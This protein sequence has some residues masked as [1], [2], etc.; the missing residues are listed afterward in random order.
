MAD[1]IILESDA[2]L[3]VDPQW[4][5]VRVVQVRDEKARVG[6]GISV[7]IKDRQWGSNLE[8]LQG[9]RLRV[10]IEIIGEAVK[11]EEWR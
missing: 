5:G 10:T 1:P 2:Y 3:F 4:P 9:K 8:H 11:D 7:H 6:E